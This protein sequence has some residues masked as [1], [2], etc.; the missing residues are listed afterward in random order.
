MKL[1]GSDYSVSNPFVVTGSPFTVSWESTTRTELYISTTPE[2]TDN[3]L[4]VYG[5]NW[6]SYERECQIDESYVEIDC[7]LDGQL[8][9]GR[10]NIT[11]LV[12]QIP[13]TLYLITQETTY[14]TDGTSLDEEVQSVSMPIQLN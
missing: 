3:S 12:K 2:V 14:V 6:G 9:G 1:N 11:S 10:E 8:I 13:T 7:N 4:E 5:Y